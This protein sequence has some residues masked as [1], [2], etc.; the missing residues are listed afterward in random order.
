MSPRVPSLVSPTCR[1]PT[2]L[3]SDWGGDTGV[4]ISREGPL[5]GHRGQ[6]A[7]TAPLGGTEGLGGDLGWGHVAPPYLGEGGGAAGAGGGA[8]G[9]GSAGGSGGKGAVRGT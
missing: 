3:H 5:Q 8:A 7:P 2:G 4:F 1:A 6:G 9:P